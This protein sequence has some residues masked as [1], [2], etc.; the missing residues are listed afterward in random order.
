MR[1]DKFLCEME[2]GS[3]SQV[4]ALIRQGAV[5]VNGMSVG[6]ADIQID[7]FSDSVCCGGR[8]LIYQKYVYYMLNK[9][10]G[11]ISATEDPAAQ[12]V[13]SLLGGDGRKGI[14]RGYWCS[15]M[16]GNWHTGFCRRK[17]MWI[18]HIG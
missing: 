10:K 14:R 9:P 17:I 2:L 6:K 18:R 3:R 16:T 11:V 15:R 13:I 1:L 4:K 5:T 7:E 8:L 12:T